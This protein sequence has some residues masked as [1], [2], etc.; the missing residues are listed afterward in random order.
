MPTAGPCGPATNHLRESSSSF[1]G[2]VFG[3]CPNRE[4]RAIPPAP[5]SDHK[6]TGPTPP[7][8]ATQVAKP[9]RANCVARPP[10]W[11]LMLQPSPLTALASNQER[12]NTRVPRA[13]RRFLPRLAAPIPPSKRR[14]FSIPPRSRVKKPS[15]PEKEW[16]PGPGSPREADRCIERSRA[17][18]YHP[19]TYMARQC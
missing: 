18:N 4:F 14:S 13:R 3:T 10:A 15:H 5:S 11:G 9:R 6:T 17:G 16:L 8:P 12:E 7:A 19:A 2:F 1:F